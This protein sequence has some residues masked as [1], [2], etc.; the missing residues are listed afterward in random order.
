LSS[1][2]V[3]GKK[4]RRIGTFLLEGASESRY[5]NIGAK[6]VPNKSPVISLNSFVLV[7]SPINWVPASTI[8]GIIMMR[9]IHRLGGPFASFLRKGNSR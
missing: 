2:T 7:L 4:L 3:I 1:S 5:T 9:V 6:A 8:M